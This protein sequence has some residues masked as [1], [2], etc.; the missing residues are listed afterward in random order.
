MNQTFL[1]VRRTASVDSCEKIRVPLEWRDR[2]LVPNN[3]SPT[4]EDDKKPDRHRRNQ[5]WQSS[6]EPEVRKALLGVCDLNGSH[7]DRASQHTVQPA[8]LFFS[9]GRIWLQTP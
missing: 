5:F 9:S 3:V 4:S 7:V 8:T 6:E 1:R 2:C